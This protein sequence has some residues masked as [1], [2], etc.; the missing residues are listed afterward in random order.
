MHGRLLTHCFNGGDA[1][2]YSEL[3]QR[4]LIFF[5]QACRL[6]VPVTQ[7]FQLMQ[8]LLAEEGPS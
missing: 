4:G 3:P 2:T 7:S 5:K 8:V 1:S 6:A